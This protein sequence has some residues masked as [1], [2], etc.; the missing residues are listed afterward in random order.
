M[1]ASTTAPISLEGWQRSTG[2]SG[3]FHSESVATFDW[4]RWQVSTG[5]S[6]NLRAEYAHVSSPVGTRHF[7]RRYTGASPV[8]TRHFSRRYTGASPVGTHHSPGT[9]P[10]CFVTRTPEQA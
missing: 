3:S 6:G 10:L 5:I 2:I 4:N 1:S 7:S 8:G 9:L